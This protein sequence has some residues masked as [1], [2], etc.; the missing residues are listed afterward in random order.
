MKRRYSPNVIN[1]FRA[2]L[3]GFN[4]S[5][6]W[7]RLITTNNH[8]QPQT[9][10][11]NHKQ[12]KWYVIHILNC[13]P[14]QGESLPWVGGGAGELGGIGGDDV[15]QNGFF[16]KVLLFDN[17]CK[18][19]IKFCSHFCQSHFYFTRHKLTQINY[20]QTTNKHKETQ[21]NANNHNGL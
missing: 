1:I 15:I 20:K 10:T 8:K 5:S 6:T 16:F 19:A 14:T 13:N 21:T 2:T 9:T 3:S 11:N 4:N 17:S 12:P 18:N 7:V